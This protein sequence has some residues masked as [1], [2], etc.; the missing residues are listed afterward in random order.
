MICPADFVGCP[1]KV[2]WLAAF[3]LNSKHFLYDFCVGL[4]TSHD[5]RLMQLILFIYISHMI[6][7]LK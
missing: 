6:M 4:L 3:F 1:A 2:V 7:D 5:G